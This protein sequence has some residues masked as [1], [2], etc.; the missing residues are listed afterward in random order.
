MTEREPSL[1][2]FDRLVG[3]W[4]TQATHPMM[5]GVVP[6]TVTFEWLEGGRFLI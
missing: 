5:D 6:G 4:S 2:A 1:D 3:A